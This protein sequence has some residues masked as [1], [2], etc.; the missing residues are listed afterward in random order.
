MV[1]GGGAYIIYFL[2]SARRLWSGPF[3][4]PGFWIWSLCSHSG[5]LC[6][7]PSVSIKRGF[8]RGSC[9]QS[10]ILAGLLQYLWLYPG[11][12][13]ERLA[14]HSCFHPALGLTGSPWLGT[15]IPAP[16]ER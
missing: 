14:E 1:W 16:E 8:W 3:C 5:V 10:Q 2:P 15:Q 4:C 12:S 7:R 6:D 9:W 11:P 13:G